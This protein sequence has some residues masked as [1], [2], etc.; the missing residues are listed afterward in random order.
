MNNF[1]TIAP[2][3]TSFL[4]D[5][6]IVKCRIQCW[7]KTIDVF[8]RPQKPVYPTFS[9]MKASQQVGVLLGSSRVIS[10]YPETKVCDVFSNRGLSAS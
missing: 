4:D 5:Q 2:V 3:D 8:S 9:T 6:D 1:A 7:V 10:L